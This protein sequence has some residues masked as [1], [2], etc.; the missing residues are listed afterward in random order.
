MARGSGSGRDGSNLCELSFPMPWLN[1][2]VVKTR[3]NAGGTKSHRR[4]LDEH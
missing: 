3:A 4:C 1:Q 2:M